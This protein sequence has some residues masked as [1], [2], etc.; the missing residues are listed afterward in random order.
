MSTVSKEE[1][2]AYIPQ[3]L[4]EKGTAIAVDEMLLY[5]K[6]NPGTS[7]PSDLRQLITQRSI[8]DLSFH[9]SD[10]HTRKMESMDEVKSEFESWIQ[11]GAEESLRR[12]LST[13]IKTEMRKLQSEDDEASLSFIESFKK[14]VHEQA[15]DPNFHF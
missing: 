6:E 1:I 5:E 15:K 3:M 11:K 4:T 9:A 10:F 7:I 12:M 14:K 8:A 13:N 2:L